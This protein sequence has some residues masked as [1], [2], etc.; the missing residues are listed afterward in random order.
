MDS[1]ATSTSQTSSL[2]WLFRVLGFTAMVAVAFT[3]PLFPAMELDSSWRMA[4]GRFF[5]EG[6]QFGTEVVFTYGPLGFA[7]GKTYWGD[8]LNVLIGWHAVQAVVFTIIIYWHAYRLTGY[9]RIFCF[10]FFFLFGLSYQDAMHMSIMALCGMELIRRSNLTWRWSSVALLVLLVILSLV[11]FTNLMLGFFLVLLAGGLELW[12]SRKLSGLRLPGLFLALFMIGWMLCGQHLGN[13]PAY[14]HSSWEISQGYQ[15]AMGLA[16]PSNQ[17]YLGLTTV[18]LMLAYLAVNFATATDR[19]RGGALTL[20]ALAYLYLNWKHGFIRADGHQIGFYYAVMTILFTSPLLL[21]ESDRLR[22]LKQGLL[23]ATAVVSLFSLEAVLP[24]LVRGALGSIQEKVNLHTAYLFTDAYGTK[25]Y[26]GKLEAERSNVDL[27]KTKATV[28]RA[29]LDVLGFEQAVAL[30][31]GFNYQPR[32]VFQGYSAYTPYLSRL[33][34]DYYASDRAPEYVLFKLQTLDGRLASMDDPH[35][36]RLLVQRYTYLYSEQGFALWRRKPGPFD[37]ASFEPKPIRSV[38]AHLGEKINL[39][40]LVDHNIWVEIDY[41][42]NLLGKLRR[43]LYRPVLVNLHITDDKGVETVH[44]LPQPIGRAGFM[45]SPVVN[46]ML[47]YMRASGGGT[48]RRAV[49]IRIDT[50]KQDRDCVQDDVTVSFSSL[51]PSDAGK[52]YFKNADK[53]KFHMFKDTPISYEALNPPNEDMIDKRPVMIMHAPS[54]MVFEVPAGATMIEG[55]FGFVPGAYQNGG[56][57]NGAQF[58]VFWSDGGDRMVL[59]ERYLNPVT[60]LNDRGLQHFSA[61][62]PK[63][64]GHVIFRID[65]GENNEYAFDWTGWTGI[66]F[67]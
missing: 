37:A 34:Y 41:R 57:T 38:A 32:P 33:N 14:F 44:R 54:Q 3:L 49:S 26:E 27:Q 56:R 53:A 51:P 11:K 7:M 5:M 1:S 50:A 10:G 6:R 65:P 45:L 24:G 20:G 61:P 47:D 16:C 43:F 23:A 48:S 55:S 22:R 19:I 64:K 30:F 21:D 35:V 39:A 58:T 18:G 29:S 42:F 2:D 63:G 17:L 52:E 36:L 62:I 31:N 59:H 28:G 46:D 66:E 15:D 13:L 25:V 4:I 8:H 67:K 40:D 12:Q 9:S 60:R